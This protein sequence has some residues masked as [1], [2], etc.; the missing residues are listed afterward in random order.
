VAAALRG[1]TSINAV[2]RCGEHKNHEQFRLMDLTMRKY[3]LLATLAAT[4]VIGAV[5]VQAQPYKSGTGGYGPGQGYGPGYM[6]GPGYGP[7]M[8]Q[9]YG[10]GMMNDG[11]GPGWMMGPGY[12]PGM[13]GYG[14]GNRGIRNG[15]AYRGQRMCWKETDSSRNFGYYEAC[16]N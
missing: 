8:G 5:A 9:G 4:A 1:L 3:L 14:P 6:M 12:G 7:G 10:Y 15:P 16:P 2:V 11:Y 13:M